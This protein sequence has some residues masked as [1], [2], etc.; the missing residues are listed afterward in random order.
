MSVALALVTA[1]FGCSS[2]KEEEQQPPAAQAPEPVR[3][4]GAER[5]E[6]TAPA[7]QE[8]AQ[9]GSTQ[10]SER[11]ANGEGMGESATALPISDPQSVRILTTVNGGE[12]EQAQL[13]KDK[14]QDSRVK[15]FAQKMIDEHKKANDKIIKL[16]KSEDLMPANSSVANDLAD[17]GSQTLT[18]LNAT[19]VPDFD[20]TY[21]DAQV[22]QHQEVLELINTRLIPGATDAKLKDA[23]LDASKM[24]A[25]HLEK[26]REIQAQL[27]R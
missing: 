24:V 1:S 26:A 2:H 19:T 17:K 13:A 21:I 5:N 9:P 22:Q 25:H 14:A 15:K 7:I 20:K 12:I 8:P 10:P 18:T 27:Q 6:P 4:T 3:T 16:Y 11:E 23:L